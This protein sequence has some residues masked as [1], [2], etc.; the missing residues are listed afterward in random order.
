GDEITLDY[1]MCNYTVEHFLARCRCGT[2]HCRGRITGWKDLPGHRK[3][4]YAGFIAPY[5]IDIDSAS[6]RGAGEPI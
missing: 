6:A 4:D 5:L 1:A 2:Q 3:A